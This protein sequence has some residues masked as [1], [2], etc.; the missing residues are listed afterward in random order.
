MILGQLEGV[1]G[2]IQCF[3]IRTSGRHRGFL[4]AEELPIVVRSFVSAQLR[5]G[6]LAKNPA[7]QRS[8]GAGQILEL[9]RWAGFLRRE[10]HKES[11]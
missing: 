10:M 5:L 11:R 9:R 8:A 4:L 2:E 6:R 3:D 1:A 7:P